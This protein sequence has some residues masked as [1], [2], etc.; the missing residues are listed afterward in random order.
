MP[1]LYDVAVIG[2]GPAGMTAGIYASRAMLKTIIFEKNA[3]GGLMALTDKLE[4]WPGEKSIAG[5]EL[6]EKMHAQA[7][8]LGCKFASEEV[9]KIEKTG[10]KQFSIKTASGS[11]FSAKTVIYAAGSVPRKAGI[12]GEKEFTGNGVSYCAV[13]DGA[14]YKGLTVAF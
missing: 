10:D 4:N 9:Q 6:A 11:E 13:C 3:Y 1:E 14:F 2:S 7:L 12:P 8:D 5:Y